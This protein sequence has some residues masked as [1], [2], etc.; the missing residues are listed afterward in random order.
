MKALSHRPG[1]ARDNKRDITVSDSS[2]FT[3]N[4]AVSTLFRARTIFRS[5][6]MRSFGGLSAALEGNRRY[7]AHPTGF[8]P[9]TFGFG[10]RHSIQLSYGCIDLQIVAET[11]QG[12]S[13]I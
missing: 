3:P 2:L 5:S 12:Q 11:E 10:G 1:A 13:R 7:L 9:V 6:R 8:E 4:T